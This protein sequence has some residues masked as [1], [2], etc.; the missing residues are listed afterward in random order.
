MKELTDERRRL[1]I[2]EFVSDF[3]SLIRR[4]EYGLSTPY[5]SVFNPNEGKC[6]KKVD[7]NKFEYRHLRSV[8]K[9]GE[10]SLF[11]RFIVF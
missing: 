10:M 4:I 3:A 2:L 6:G 7:Q 1:Q 5:L 11:E 8:E 9:L